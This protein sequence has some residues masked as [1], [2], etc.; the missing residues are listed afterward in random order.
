VPRLG[1]GQG[2]DESVSPARDMSFLP[3]LRTSSLERGQRDSEPAG[4][5]HRILLIEAY[6]PAK[7]QPAGAGSALK[8]RPNTRPITA[9]VIPVLTASRKGSTMITIRFPKVSIEYMLKCT[10]NQTKKP[11]IAPTLKPPSNEPDPV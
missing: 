9:P 11:T 6:L 2:I 5:R 4:V 3:D 10:P 1:S 8:N 7:G